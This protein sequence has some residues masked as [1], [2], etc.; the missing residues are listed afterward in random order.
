MES[1]LYFSLCL[2][3]HDHSR[4]WW[5]K[6]TEHSVI[7]TDPS[8]APKRYCCHPGGLFCRQQC[9]GLLGCWSDQGGWGKELLSWRSV[10]PLIMLEWEPLM[11][12]AEGETAEP[13]PSP[14]PGH[15]PPP[16]PHTLSC[17]QMKQWPWSW[18]ESWTVVLLL[19]HPTERLKHRKSKRPLNSPAVLWQKTTQPFPVLFS[20]FAGV[21]HKPQDSKG[22][23]FH[24][25]PCCCR[26]APP[27]SLWGAHGNLTAG[28]LLQVG[29]RLSVRAAA[30][31]YC[32]SLPLK[33]S[34]TP[35]SSSLLSP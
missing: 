20:F 24:P 3:K 5:I 35:H 28:P 23:E 2:S 10:S 18:H 11:G 27:G 9:E 31:Q 33:T 16:P 29:K 32:Y 22:R 4:V 21:L 25:K 34:K 8:P 1:R 14:P 17:G 30:P 6:S 12:R 26:C 13:F 19:Q 7:P 15:P